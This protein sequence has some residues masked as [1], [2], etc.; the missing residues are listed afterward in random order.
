[1]TKLK[2]PSKVNSL[3]FI[4]REL[5]SL[6]IPKYIFFTKKNF[7]TNKNL[8]LNKI[9]KI[10]KGN[11]II[12]SSALNEDTL[13]SSNAGKYDSIIVKKKD[14]KNLENAIFKIIKKFTKKN[15]QI[16][17]QN[18]IDKP[19]ISG[20]I[21]TKDINTNS[22]Y[23]Q[24]EYDTS[25]KSNLVTSGNL[26]PSLKTLIIFKKIKNI[27]IKFRKL[28]N[29][30]R[31]LEILFANERLDVEFCIKNKKVFIFQCRSLLG[32]KKYPIL[33]NMIRY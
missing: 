12:R 26:N 8:Y 30:C 5:N 18:F 29:A 15:D 24:I 7:K 23:Y 11:I 17:V 6:N 19:D 1:M 4:K 21:F 33:I 14:F 13:K 3:N 2:I 20:V 25:K 31:K 10:F 32:N 9:K 22:D 28:I 16:L 27:P